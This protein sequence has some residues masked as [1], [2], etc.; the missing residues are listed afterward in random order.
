RLGLSY[1]FGSMDPANGG[2][3][4]SGTVKCVLDRSG[5]PNVPRTACEQYLWLQNAGT[6]RALRPGT[7]PDWI[8]SQLR[9]GDLLFWRGTYVTNREPDVSHV[10]IYLGRHPGTGKPVMFGARST[11][12]MKGVHGNAVDFYEFN[13]VPRGKS[14]FIGFGTV[15]AR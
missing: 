8:L 4:C 10:M 15:P 1:R 11:T 14:E 9:P 2:L 3:D 6:L 5:V 7:S 12:G 13:P